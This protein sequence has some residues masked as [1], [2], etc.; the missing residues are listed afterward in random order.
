MSY[1]RCSY[2]DQVKEKAGVVL[3]QVIKEMVHDRD[4]RKILHQ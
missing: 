4:K 1:P 2:V 3:Y